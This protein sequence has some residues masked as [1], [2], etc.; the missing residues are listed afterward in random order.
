M[1]IK[2]SLKTMIRTLITENPD[3]AYQFPSTKYTREILTT[4]IH[5][6]QYIQLKAHPKT[7]NKLCVQFESTKASFMQSYATTYLRILPW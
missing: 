3:P 5:G 7:N 4:E 6:I 2:L 1:N